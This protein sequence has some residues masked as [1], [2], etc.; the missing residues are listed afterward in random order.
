[1]INSDQLAEVQ[2]TSKTVDANGY[3]FDF[4]IAPFF[5]AGVESFF[6]R[7]P[8]GMAISLAFVVALLYLVLPGFIV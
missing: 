1:V 6:F 7:T 5:S 8:I 4:D 2:I 3:R